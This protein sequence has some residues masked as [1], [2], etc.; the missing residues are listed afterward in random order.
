[1]VEKA[2]LSVRNYKYWYTQI[3]TDFIPK[4]EIGYNIRIRNKLFFHCRTENFKIHFPHILLRL[5]IA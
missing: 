4:G 2:L 1:M 3:L 5:G